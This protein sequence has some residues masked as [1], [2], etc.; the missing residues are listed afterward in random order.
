FLVD[1]NN[2][3]HWQTPYRGLEAL[4]S[5]FNLSLGFA[6]FFLVRISGALYFINNINNETIKERAIKSIKL[7]ML[8]FLF[9][10][11]VFLSL[12]FTKDGFAYDENAFVFIQEYKYLQNFLDMPI[13]LG[14]FVVGVLMVVIAV[15]A[16]IHLNMT[17]CIKTGGV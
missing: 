2:F 8:I 10:F 5:V 7:D 12:L 4:G 15:F 14:M 9:F 6:L 3:S 1:E 11:L 17:C 13:V 16:T